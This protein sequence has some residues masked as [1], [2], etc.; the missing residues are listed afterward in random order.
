M[1]ITACAFTGHRPSRFKFGYDEEDVL[2]NKIKREMLDQILALYNNGITHFYTGMAMG[3]DIWAAELVI[4]MMKIYPDMQLYCVI[5]YEEQAMKWSQEYRNRYY[6]ILEQSTRNILISK[7]YSNVCYAQRNRYLVDNTQILLAVY[8][9]S[10]QKSGTKQTVA[11]AK[12]KQKGIIYIDPD[13]A[14]LTPITI[15][16]TSN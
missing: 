14:K 8:Q 4:A 2:C 6:H 16:A 11:Y 10:E 9:H 12:Q 3:V 5:P 7:R 15:C 13:S 1:E